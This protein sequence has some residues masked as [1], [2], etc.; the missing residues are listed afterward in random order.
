METAGVDPSGRLRE[1]DVYPAKESNAVARIYFNSV[2]TNAG[3]EFEG[4]C[5]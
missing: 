3:R 5:V 4:R 1:C 2:D